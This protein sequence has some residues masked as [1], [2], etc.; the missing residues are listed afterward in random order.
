MTKPCSERVDA[1]MRDRLNDIR[2]LWELYNEDSEAYDDDLGH[3][4]E[5]GLCFDYVAPG[6]FSDQTEGYFRWQLST[7]GPG[8]EFRI[9]ADKAGPYTW[10]VYRVEYWFLDRFD[11]AYKT[12]Y[13]DDRELIEDIFSALFVDTGTTDQA[14]EE[15]MDL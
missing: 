13:D 1:N 4:Y 6:T 5:Y 2:A 3:I 14:Y 15:A 11:G 7:G 10:S 8:D 12:L 9:Y